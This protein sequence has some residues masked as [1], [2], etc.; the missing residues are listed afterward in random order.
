M[1]KPLLRHPK[2]LKLPFLDI[3]DL[4]V[5]SQ[6]FEKYL[7]T[8]RQVF[9]TCRSFNMKLNG[10]K[11]TFLR[12][13]CT[14]LGRIVDRKGYRADPKYIQGIMAIQPPT[15]KKQLEK[16]IPWPWIGCINKEIVEFGW[17][18]IHHLFYC[19]VIDFNVVNVI[20]FGK[21]LSNFHQVPFSFDQTILSRFIRL[22]TKIFL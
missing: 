9:E 3:D 15:N 6:T 12:S 8:L 17:F 2:F 22:S 11:C 20:T 4:L 14:F 13:S 7:D 10:P 21:V 16:L 1:S 5:H 18:G 19:L